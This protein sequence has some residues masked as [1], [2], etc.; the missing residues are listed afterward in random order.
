M[1]EILSHKALASLEKEIA[2]IKPLV[3]TIKLLPSQLELHLVPWIIESLFN[4]SYLIGGNRSSSICEKFLRKQ[5][6][7]SISFKPPLLHLEGVFLSVA[8]AINIFTVWSLNSR[9]SLHWQEKNKSKAWRWLFFR[10][11]RKA[12][13]WYITK[14][15]KELSNPFFWHIEWK[16]AHVNRECMNTSS[17]FHHLVTTILISTIMNQCSIPNTSLGGEW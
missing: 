17:W 4:S 9:A 7:K 14:A 11:P 5:S 8:S 2:L 13:I 1:L 10:F 16:I 6:V 12:Y 15:D 3:S